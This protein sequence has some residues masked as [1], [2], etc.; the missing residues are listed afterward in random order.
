[1]LG[2]YPANQHSYTWVRNGDYMVASQ[3]SHRI[4]V[5]LQRMRELCPAVEHFA[6][7][8]GDVPAYI[9]NGRLLYWFEQLNAAA[10]M[11]LE[12]QFACN[13]EYAAGLKQEAEIRLGVVTTECAWLNG[14]S[15]RVYD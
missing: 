1:M 5:A 12:S 14:I 9:S 6:K 11:V 4:D 8:G 3:L 7:Y 2:G 15:P 13:A 10:E